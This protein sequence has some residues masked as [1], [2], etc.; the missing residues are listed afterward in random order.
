M[1]VLIQKE[2]KRKCL[3]C[4]KLIPGKYRSWFKKD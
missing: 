2:I 1:D 4:L 3:V